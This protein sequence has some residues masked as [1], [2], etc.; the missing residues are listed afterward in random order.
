MNPGV[1]IE[2][3]FLRR[4]TPDS[5]L[6]QL[7]QDILSSTRCHDAIQLARFGLHFG[8]NLCDGQSQVRGRETGSK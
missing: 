8:T 6:Y 2:D 7:E 3:F 4:K 1:K 5:I